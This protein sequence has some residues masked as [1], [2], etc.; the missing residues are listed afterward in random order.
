MRIGFVTTLLWDRYGSFWW[1]LVADA[2]AEPVRSDP[3][4]I[5]AAVDDP[6]AGH[7]RALAFRVATADA[8]ALPGC[9]LL[10]APELNPGF[11]TGRGGGQDPWIVSFPAALATSVS[12]LPPVV[13][14]P[15]G[16]GAPVEAKA[17][18]VLR[19]IDRDPTRVRRVWE[20]HRARA[21]AP[22]TR[23]VRWQVRPSTSRTVGL[24]GP[25]WLVNDA[26]EAALG[27]EDEH[28]V[29]Q[30][31]LDPAELRD[32]GARF[33]PELVPTD[34]EAVGAARLFGRRG[35]VAA[36]RAV[37]DPDVGSDA[38]LLRRIEDVVRKEIEVVSIRDLD[39]PV[40]RL[41]PRGAA[42]G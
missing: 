25:A 20:R 18:E 4:A 10:I 15:V 21:T 41:L 36:V 19:T 3:A 28:L 39:D 23:G 6:R 7:V 29:G 13:G 32:E 8:V 9:D 5:R 33:D 38:W 11:E 24:V 40:G 17:L 12:G 35:V 27:A 2:G 1:D 26:V 16:P 22:R 34:A 37:V 30:H 42:P 14:V 31:R